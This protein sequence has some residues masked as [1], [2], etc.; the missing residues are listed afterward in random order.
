MMDARQWAKV[1]RT[2]VFQ[3]NIG[4]RIMP[5]SR[6]RDPANNKGGKD[7]I[8]TR[9][10]RYVDPQTKYTSANATTT[11]VEVRATAGTVTESRSSVEVGI[12]ELSKN[13]EP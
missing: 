9:I 3:R 5:V 10:A 1:G 2:P 11:N 7:S 4:N 13:T 12:V 6:W 8:A